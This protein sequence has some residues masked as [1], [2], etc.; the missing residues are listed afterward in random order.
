MFQ[1]SVVNKGAYQKG[2]STHIQVTNIIDS[3]Q[4]IQYRD[5]V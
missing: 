2:I 4:I 3:T 5:V 1:H